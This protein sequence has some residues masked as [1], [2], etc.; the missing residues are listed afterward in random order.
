MIFK[1]EAKMSDDGRFRYWLI[2]QWDATR[3]LLY[4]VMLNPSTADH[5]VPDAT[6]RRCMAFARAL[7]FGGTVVLNLY[8]YRTKSPKVLRAAGKPVGDDNEYWHDYW[9]AE[10]AATGGK[11]V[12]AWGS[13]VKAANTEVAA[14]FARLKTY[15]LKPHYLELTIHGAPKHPLYLKSTCTLHPWPSITEEEL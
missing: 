6:L 4:F 5:I 1:S 3:P 14:L 2:R 8:A 7:G 10:A 12:C 15:R 13:N 11:V 9:L